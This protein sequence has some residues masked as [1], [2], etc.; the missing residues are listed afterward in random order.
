VTTTEKRIAEFSDYPGFLNALRLRATELK[1]AVSG[2]VNSVAGL[3]D[4]YL[5]K[6]IGPR[7]VRRVGMMSMAPI[8][9]V[10]G[11][12]LVM[13]EDSSAMQRYVGRLRQRDQ[14]LVRS[15]AFYVTLRKSFFRKIGRD[16]GTKRMG[17]LSRRQR[18]QLARK[19]VNA[20]WSK[21]TAAE[22]R[23]HGRNLT[24]IR[25]QKKAKRSRRAAANRGAR[26]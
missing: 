4:A 25:L 15:D 5:Q 26:S 9:G 13:I 3:P 12:R 1:I 16:G 18:R 7:A 11:V 6:I 17:K 23:E 10:L 14:R 21:T 19:A 8:L 24:R 2:D 20:R 22:R